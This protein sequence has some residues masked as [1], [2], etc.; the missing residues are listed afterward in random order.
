[1]TDP[2]L[3]FQQFDMDYD[4]GL[5]MLAERQ[6]AAG[7]TRALVFALILSFILPRAVTRTA[8]TVW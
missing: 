2:D 1:M 6:A 7:R 3:S 4:N 8:P 5:A